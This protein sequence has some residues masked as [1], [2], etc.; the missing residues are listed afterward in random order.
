M[1]QCDQDNST[2]K[3]ILKQLPRLNFDNPS[4]LG[5]IIYIPVMDLGAPLDFEKSA[6]LQP[7][8]AVF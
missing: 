2:S 4:E 1:I 5:L 8:L 7:L 6:P 3:K